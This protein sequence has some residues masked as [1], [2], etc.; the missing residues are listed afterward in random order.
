MA[1]TGAGGDDDGAEGLSPDLLGERLGDFEREFVLGC[2]RAKG[3]R[4]AA[5]AGVQQGDVAFR[6]ALGEPA[7]V[8]EI[9]EVAA[10]VNG[11]SLEDLSAATSATAQRFFGKLS[12][13]S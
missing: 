3:A 1:A 9:S 8:K 11:C 5:A 12:G 4:H 7:Y 2:Q 6:Q 10:Q 13:P